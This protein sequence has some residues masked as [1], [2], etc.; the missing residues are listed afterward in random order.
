MPRSHWK[1]VISFGLVSIPVILSPI[2]KKEAEI[3]FHQI[4]KK[5]NSRIKYQRININTGKV[6]PWER[7]TRAY[8]YDEETN[9]PVP[10]PVLKQVAGDNARTIAIDSFI[11]KD[12]LSII[13][14]TNCYYLV[15]GKGGDKGYVIL[16]EALEQTNKIGI[17]KVIISTKE[18][19]SLCCRIKMRLLCAC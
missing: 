7:I 18:Y 13:T 16:R 3:S 10:D 11:D 6:V 1:G 15:P 19:L 5:D 8:E 4:D 14:I 12:E 9:I 17:A 2:E